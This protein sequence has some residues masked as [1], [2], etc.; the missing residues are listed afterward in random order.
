MSD[1][2]TGRNNP[3]LDL[4][5]CAAIILVL[6]RH[7]ERALHTTGGEPAQSFLQT[8]FMNGWVGVDL[9]FVLSG[10]LISVH[11]I[12]AGVGSGDFLVWRYLAMRALRIVPAY[13]AV[14]GLV[15]VGV[16]PLFT[17]NSHLLPVRI[18][19]HLMFLQDYLP[20]DINVVFWSLGVEEKFYLLAPLLIFA[21]LRLRAGWLRSGLLML[22]FALPIGLRTA[23]FL[24]L[25]GVLDYPE[26]WQIFRSPFHMT[27]EGFVVG[28]GIA[29]A[30][31]SGLVPQSP[32]VGLF[33]L[34]AATVVLLVW[35]ASDDFMATLDLGDAILQPALI[36]ILAGA[37]TLGAVQ[38]AAVPMPLTRPFQL[39]SKLSYSLYLIHYPLIPLVLAAT[40]VHGPMAFW[41][42]YIS[43]SL[44]VALLL[45]V[46]V[47]RPFLRIKDR[48]SQKTM[49][50][51]APAE[52]AAKL[53]PAAST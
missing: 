37:I 4:V 11:L 48:L 13:Y 47:E 25:E 9:F 16:F 38:L 46:A 45:H 44:I 41:T 10:Y 18:G 15:A 12:R 8:I 22:C 6:L 51:A 28:I 29:T 27:L 31:H 32:K 50:V 24:R 19:Y 40:A 43:A 1:I 23:A 36:A 34:C 30:Q 20:S 14:L 26:F 17:V 5:R 42:S 33:V 3:W 53:P 35:L 39:L 7:G 49:A 21:L 52:S 2:A